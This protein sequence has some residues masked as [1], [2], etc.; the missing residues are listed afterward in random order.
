MSTRDFLDSKKDEEREKEEEKEKEKA[1]MK[2]KEK[3]KDETDE[4]IKTI[5]RKIKTFDQLKREVYEIKR[6]YDKTVED[7]NEF[8][9]KS[10]EVLN[11]F[12][13]ISKNKG[14]VT[15]EQIEEEKNYKNFLNIELVEFDK[16]F[17]FIL[18]DIKLEENAED[19]N[20]SN[21]ANNTKDNKNITNNN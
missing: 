2:E 12:A 7:I 19:K 10:E 16:K 9:E 8:K 1:K 3:E 17:K 15:F 14:G 21:N 11:K 4:K 13:K 20:I 6:E 18:G 5:F